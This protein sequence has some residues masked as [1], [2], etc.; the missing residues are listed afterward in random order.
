M[1]VRGGIGGIQYEPFSPLVPWS[2]VLIN[3][4]LQRRLSNICSCHFL[5]VVGIVLS[6]WQGRSHLSS[7]RPQRQVLY[8]PRV[9]EKGTDTERFS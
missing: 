1:C 6:S 9:A 2:P 7:C 5:S 4:P 3:K 8:R